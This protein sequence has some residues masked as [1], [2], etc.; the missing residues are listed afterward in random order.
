MRHIKSGEVR[1]ILYRLG[2]HECRECH[3]ATGD[4]W[5]YKDFSNKNIVICPQCKTEYNLLD[6]QI[7]IIEDG[8]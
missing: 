8:L 6:E 1:D 4:D 3:C 2:I 7:D 5:E